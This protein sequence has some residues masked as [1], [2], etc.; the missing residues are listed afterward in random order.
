MEGGL[1]PPPSGYATEAANAPRSRTCKDVG[2][3]YKQRQVTK[4]QH[5]MQQQL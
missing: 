5:L 1:N 4:L 2:P 3:S